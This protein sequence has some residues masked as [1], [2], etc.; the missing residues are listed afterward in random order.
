MKT[1]KTNS[2]QKLGRAPGTLIFTG[3]KKTENISITYI[4][5]NAD[6]YNETVLKDIDSAY[7]LCDENYINWINISGLHDAKIIEKIG[8][9]FNLHK[10]SLE[11]ILS[12]GQRP[13]FED[14][15]TYIYVV[16]KM[17]VYDELKN[18]PEE[19]QVSFILKDGVL[20]TFQEKDGDVFEH[21]RQRLREAKGSIRKRSEDYLLYALMD[22]IV[23]YYFLIIEKTG[24]SIEDIESQLL[25]NIETDTLNRLHEI[26]RQILLLRRAVYPVREVINRMEKY[27]SSLIK[28]E[29]NV[30]I[31]DLYDHTIQII[32][33]IEVFRDMMSGIMDLYMN[34][35]SNRMNNVMKVLTIIATIFIPL[36]FVVGVYGM[37][38]ENM[39][40]LAW[41]WGYFAV[42]AFMFALVIFMLWLFRRKKWL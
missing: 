32:E 40:E 2:K 25:S 19:E 5:Y 16:L 26:R 28:S 34:M 31:R 42:L 35:I 33:T 13:K 10:L 1:V 15:E 21:V 12:I 41:K 4:Q 38:F 9:L 14:F 18:A 23:D 37:N 20:I 36:T 11:D 24:N 8:E 27:D 39:P 22:S 17:F 29:N 6:S 3:K 30:F 7:K